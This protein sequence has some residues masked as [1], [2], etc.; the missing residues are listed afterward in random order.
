MDRHLELLSRSM[1][2][3]V[4]DLSIVWEALDS[5]TAKEYAEINDLKAKTAKSLVEIG[6]IDGDDV[7]KQLTE[8]R[9]SDFYGL[10]KNDIDISG[11]LNNET[12]QNAGRMGAES[13][14]SQVGGQAVSLPGSSEPTV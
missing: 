7:R 8:D 3:Q 12:D 14:G 9:N 1:Q 2:L 10:D 5:P 11:W 6:A 4:Q 13:E